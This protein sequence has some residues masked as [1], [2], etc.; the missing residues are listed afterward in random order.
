MKFLVLFYFIFCIGSM[1][2]KLVWPIINLLNVFTKAWFELPVTQ[3]V[4]S[5]TTFGTSV[6]F[7]IN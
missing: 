5:D 6:C 3:M 1:N 7:V 4:N 2:K